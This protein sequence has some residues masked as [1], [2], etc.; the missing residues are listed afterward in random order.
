MREDSFWKYKLFFWWLLA[1]NEI[2]LEIGK[3]FYSGSTKLLFTCLEEI[4][5]ERGL[6]RIV[7][8]HKYFRSLVKTSRTSSEK[9]A[10]DLSNLLSLC[11]EEDFEEKKEIM[12][13]NNLFF[14]QLFRL[15]AKCSGHFA[16]FFSAGLSDFDFAYLELLQRRCFFPKIGSLYLFQ[17]WRNFPNFWQAFEM[18]KFWH[19]VAR[20]CKKISLR[21]FFSEK[22]LSDFEWNKIQRLA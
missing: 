8:F 15:W 6:L 9:N 5:V 20:W 16:V 11:T 17:I 14:L 12:F 13:L 2:I 19:P 10:A 22:L 4:L 3:V 1:F 7:T 18:F 21:I